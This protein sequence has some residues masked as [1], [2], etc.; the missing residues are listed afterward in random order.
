MHSRVK[1]NL[2]ETALRFSIIP[3]FFRETT[4]DSS[5]YAA[6]EA[7]TCLHLRMFLDR[8]NFSE[9]FGT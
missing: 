4:D 7:G 5:D 9:K 1:N 8:Y 3:Y 2:I 6:D